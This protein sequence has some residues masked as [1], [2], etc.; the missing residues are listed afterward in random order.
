[1][2]TKVLH[3]YVGYK[4][5]VWHLSSKTQCMDFQKHNDGAVLV[6]DLCILFE[7]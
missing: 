4:K 7:F 6:G 5:I 1:M 3:K 2:E